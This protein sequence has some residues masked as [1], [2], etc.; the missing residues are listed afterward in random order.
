MSSFYEIILLVCV[1][2]GSSGLCVGRVS[3]SV[4][5]AAHLPSFVSV[6]CCLVWVFVL[7]LGRQLI[8]YQSTVSSYP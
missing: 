8:P 4:Y 1:H 2:H 7:P 6:F 3:P 5:I